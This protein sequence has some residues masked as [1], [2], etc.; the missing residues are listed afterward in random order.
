MPNDDIYTDDD[1]AAS[2]E[3]DIKNDSFK[4]INNAINEPMDVSM[5]NSL[6]NSNHL[7]LNDCLNTYCNKTFEIK[8]KHHMFGGNYRQLPNYAQNSTITFYSSN[9]KSINSNNNM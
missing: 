4:V 6:N 9:D 5:A 3:T 1:S 7:F 8:Y 2:N